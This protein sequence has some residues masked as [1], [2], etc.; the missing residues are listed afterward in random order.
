LIPE[1]SVLIPAYGDVPYLTSALDSVNSSLC[2]QDIEIIL[3]LDRLDPKYENIIRSYDSKYV[4]RIFQSSIPGIVA[5]LNMGIQK[6]SS[7]YIARLDADD[8][9]TPKRLHEQY[10]FLENNPQVA[11]VGSYVEII[12]GNSTMTGIK[13]FPRTSLEISQSIL[14]NSPFA[15]PAVMF[16]KELV[17]EMGSYRKFY[18]NSED[19]D[20]WLRLF[21]KHEFA[22]IEKLLTKYREHDKQVSILN[23]KKMIFAGEAA[24]TSKSNRDLGLTELEILFKDLKQWSHSSVR[25]FLRLHFKFL[26]R[27]TWFKASESIKRKH[28]I[29]FFMYF[30]LFFLI[31]PLM[32]T[33]KTYDFFVRKLNI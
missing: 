18:E 19:Y 2:A 6:C 7:K 29:K 5:A 31:S 14:V 1:I 26:R 33:K 25:I 20:L 9:M 13:K 3:V 15:H 21:E 16:R 32:S 4:L 23:M 27:Y 30:I 10:Y 22:N 17:E 11:V 28:F 8:L 12:D 24:R